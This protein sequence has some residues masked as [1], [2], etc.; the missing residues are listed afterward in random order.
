MSDARRVLIVDDN[1]DAADTLRACLALELQDTQITCVYD[2][3]AAYEAAVKWAP[4]VCILDIGM[5]R[6]DGYTLAKALCE[7][8]S[9]KPLLIACTGYGRPHDVETA[10]QAG[11][12]TTFSNH[13]RRKA[14]RN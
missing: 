9:P 10:L 2:P 14:S 7:N 12:I 1:R 3:E 4:D 13:V 8:C 5:P 11:S 6:V